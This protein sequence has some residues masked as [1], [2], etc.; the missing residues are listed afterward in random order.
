MNAILSDS[1]M[2][3]AVVRLVRNEV[4]VLRRSL[5]THHLLLGLSTVRHEARQ[6]ASHA[7]RVRDGETDETCAKTHL[8]V[9]SSLHK[10]PGSFTTMH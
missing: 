3:Y 9:V 6:E 7:E 4:R 8:C 2:K 10:L 1:Y 5:H